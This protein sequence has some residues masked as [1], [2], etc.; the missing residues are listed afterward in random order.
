MLSQRT[1]P[2]SRLSR[3]AVD[4]AF[5]SANSCSMFC[6]VC[7]IVRSRAWPSS[8]KPHMRQT[9]QNSHPPTLIWGCEGS[10]LKHSNVFSMERIS[11]ACHL[12]GS[13][14][15]L[16]KATVLPRGFSE[17]QTYLWRRVS[18]TPLSPLPFIH[19]VALFR[20]IEVLLVIWLSDSAVRHTLQGASRLNRGVNRKPSH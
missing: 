5:P 2:S 17:I 19:I 14:I 13:L 4:P 20:I 11:N 9:A 16:T 12:G 18:G 1:P 7:S 10:S 3:A 8:L 15:T 6:L